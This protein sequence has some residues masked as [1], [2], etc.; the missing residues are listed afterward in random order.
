MSVQAMTRVVTLVVT[1]S[2]ATLL[3]STPAFP[4]VAVV[5]IGNYARMAITAHD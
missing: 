2:A 1:G 3:A 4:F 5:A